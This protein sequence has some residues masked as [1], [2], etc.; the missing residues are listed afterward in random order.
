MTSVRR[1][2]IWLPDDGLPADVA[3]RVQPILIRHLDEIPERERYV[4]E[5]VYELDVRDTCNA[6]GD[7][8]RV[9]R[10]T[11]DDKDGF[12]D[13]GW[14][15]HNGGVYPPGR[16]SSAFDSADPRRQ[17]AQVFLQVILSSCGLEDDEHSAHPRGRD[18]RWP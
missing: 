10:A 8:P 2:N 17:E 12:V 6:Y 18:C 13:L 14:G 16:V 5:T 7:V 11:E 9:W 3:N 4:H 1:T 15:R